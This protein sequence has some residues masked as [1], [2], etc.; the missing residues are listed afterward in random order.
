MKPYGQTRA[1]AGKLLFNFRKPQIVPDQIHQVSRIFPVMDREGR[2]HADLLGILPQQPRTDGMKRPGPGQRV[3]QRSGLVAEHRFADAFHSA[4]H[5]HTG[6]A[7]EGQQQDAARISPR[8]DQMRDPMGQCVGLARTS[9][10]D[11][12]QRG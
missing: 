4:R 7:R 6:A 12:Q 9:P 1:L 11:D 8:G 5:L 3:R 2:V 10:G